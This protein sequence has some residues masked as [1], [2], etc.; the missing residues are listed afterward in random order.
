MTSSLCSSQTPR[1]DKGGQ[2]RGQDESAQELHPAP[3]GGRRRQ[4][5]WLPSEW[6]WSMYRWGHQQ[7]CTDPGRDRK[8]AW[9]LYLCDRRGKRALPFIS[10]MNMDWFR[11]CANRFPRLGKYA[12][13]WGSAWGSS[14]RQAQ[15]RHDPRA[16]AP[17]GAG[18]TAP[19]LSDRGEAGK[20]SG[21][22]RSWGG[23]GARGGCH[24][25][26]AA[27]HKATPQRKALS[28]ASAVRR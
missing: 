4:F 10:P 7:V 6:P 14:T 28:V 27:R 15:R 24:V 19:P 5:P 26:R 9:L 23:G 8:E 17:T 2:A 12:A 22:S 11:C 21:A 20:S 3:K 18:R 13:I 16:R 25:Q 1:S